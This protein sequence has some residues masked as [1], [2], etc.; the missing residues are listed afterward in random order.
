MKQLRIVV[1]VI[2]IA[3][4][5][6][7]VISVFAQASTS[8]WPFFVEVSSNTT[9]PG[10][11]DFVAPFAVMDKARE[12]MAD[13]RLFDASNHE[14]PYAVRVR[15]EVD[16]QREIAANTFNEVVAGSAREVSVDLGED[17]GA[18]NAIEI[19]TVGS[20]FRR[21]VEVEGSDSG[22]EWR[23]LETNGVLFSFSSQNNAADSSRITY[24]TSRYRY[25]RVRVLRDELTDDNPP[26]VTG[27]RVLMSVREQGELATWN[28][29]VPDYQLLRNQGAHASVWTLDLGAR[30][31][32]DRLTLEIAD[33]SFS[34]PF[35]IESLDDPQNPRLLASGELTR[36]TTANTNPL[37]IT[38]DEETH[39]RKLRLLFTDYSNP[40]L[41]ITSIQASAPARQIVFELKEAPALPLRLFFGNATVTEPRY[42]FEKEL[43]A[44]LTREP[45]QTTVGEVVANAEF[46]PE[47]LPLTERLPWLIYL[48]LTASSVALGLILLS[49]ARRTL[50][51]TPQKAE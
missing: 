19:Q 50:Q 27:V 39:T 22:K 42:D 29:P 43:S 38:F 26:E 28:V 21:R 40:T 49:L 4:V 23:R 41:S 5:T 51:P 12:D 47:P 44:K 31:P 17:P 14:I 34:R 1:V 20:N 32:C 36:R 7:P 35:Q 37:V 45:I 3:T 24:R 46:R 13:L 18:H 48:V 11:Y 30:V 25:L 33:G 10:V 15:R 9:A 6:L 16:E 2:L 8:A